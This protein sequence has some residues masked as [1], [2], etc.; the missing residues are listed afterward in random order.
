MKKLGKKLAIG[1]I[2]FYTIKGIL[3]TA[4]LLWVFFFR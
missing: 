4:A 1:V 2:L 3:V